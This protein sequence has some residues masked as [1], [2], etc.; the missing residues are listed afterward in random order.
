MKHPD[1]VSQTIFCESVRTEQTGLS[2]ILGIFPDNI[3]LEPNAEMENTGGVV[4]PPVIPTFCAYTRIRLPL[5]RP[6]DSPIS[7]SFAA[8]TGDVIFNHV[9]EQ[10]FI[11]KSMEDALQQDNEYVILLAQISTPGFPVLHEGRY[12]MTA[13][14][15]GDTY[16]SGAIRFAIGHR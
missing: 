5:N 10:D 3:N 4:G 12:V 14:Y 7:L 16:F 1:L 11:Q 15:K 9:F 8:P 6:V 2:M 13:S